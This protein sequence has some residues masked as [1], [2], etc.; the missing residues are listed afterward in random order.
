[1][2]GIY[3]GMYNEMTSFWLKYVPKECHSFVMIKKVKMMIVLVTF[4]LLTSRNCPI[5]VI[6]GPSMADFSLLWH[7]EV[8]ENITHSSN[9]TYVKFIKY[10]L[11]ITCIK[12]PR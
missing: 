1:M 4:D 6:C 3:N 5:I 7:Y 2:P 8:V 11:I 12:L 10:I 9:K